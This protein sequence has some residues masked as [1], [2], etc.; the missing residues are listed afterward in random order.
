MTSAHSRATSRTFSNPDKAPI[1]APAENRPMFPQKC[2]E[3]RH[4]LPR[5]GA[6][7]RLG[8]GR[9]EG[10]AEAQACQQAEHRGHSAKCRRK[11]LEPSLGNGLA[12]ATIL[13]RRGAEKNQQGRRPEVRQ[14]LADPAPRSGHHQVVPQA[15]GQQPKQQVS[16]ESSGE[17]LRREQT[18]NT[19]PLVCADQH[20]HHR[21]NAG[22]QARRPD[23]QS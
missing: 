15:P 12:R 6:L 13:H 2:G 5:P 10:R 7:C 8:H 3:E 20:W 21:W 1:A 9:Q 22:G 16:D 19:P 23:G 11:P 17:E 14:A 4:A 18:G